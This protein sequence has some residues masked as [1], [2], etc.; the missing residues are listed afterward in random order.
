M[1]N[2]STSLERAYHDISR[3]RPAPSTLVEALMPS[4]RRGVTEL[5]RPDTQRRLSALDKDQLESVCIRVQAFKAEIAPAWSAD[6]VDQI[7]SA[8]RKI[9]ELR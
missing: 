1:I 8:W 7:I 5:I 4:L 6:D 2:G 9:S 3:N